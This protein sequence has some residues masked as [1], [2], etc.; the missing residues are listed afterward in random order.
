MKMCYPKNVEFPVNLDSKISTVSDAFPISKMKM[1][2]P[3]NVEF[4]VNL[5]SKISTVS[6]AFPIYYYLLLLWSMQ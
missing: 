5:D 1:C 4:P 6:D 2:Y 3:K